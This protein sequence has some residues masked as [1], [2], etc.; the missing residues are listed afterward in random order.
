[1]ATMSSLS[2]VSSIIGFGDSIQTIILIFKTNNN[3]YYAQFS[4]MV[5]L[6]I[7]FCSYFGTSTKATKL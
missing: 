5:L 2:F 6:L 4:K 3:Y 7:S 1:M